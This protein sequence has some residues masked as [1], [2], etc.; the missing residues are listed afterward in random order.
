M[1]KNFKTKTSFVENYH[2]IYPQTVLSII[3]SRFVQSMHGNSNIHLESTRVMFGKT[4]V[5]KNGK[6]LR[7][8]W[9]DSFSE[10]FGNGNSE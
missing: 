3:I 10:Y 7:C 5:S 8:N 1:N 6:T 4:K 2:I 9:N